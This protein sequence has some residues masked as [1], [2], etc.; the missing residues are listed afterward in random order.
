ML[1]GAI[2]HDLVKVGR[3]FRWRGVDVS[4]ER[5]LAED[6]VDDHVPFYIGTVARNRAELLRQEYR[7]R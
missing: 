2:D 7:L 4:A 5:E 1:N 6:D 3:C